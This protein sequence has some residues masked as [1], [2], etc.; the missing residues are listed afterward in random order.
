[1]ADIIEVEKNRTILISEDTTSDIIE[2]DNTSILTHEIVRSEIIDVNNE[3]EIL[4]SSERGLPGKDGDKHYTHS[5]NV[6][7]ATWNINHG[8]NKFPSVT[9]VDSGGS[10]V[11]GDVKFINNSNV[12]VIFSASF[13]GKAY[14]N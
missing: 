14:C 6:A 2:L 9:V 7:S 11:E 13:S 8:L 3:N 5:Q 1:M 10:V 4:T 12:E